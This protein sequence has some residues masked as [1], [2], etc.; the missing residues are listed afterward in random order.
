MVAGLLCTTETFKMGSSATH[1]A[2]ASVP[3]NEICTIES[4]T[5][6]PAAE[7]AET[8]PHV[9]T[10][11]EMVAELDFSASFPLE[12]ASRH[13]AV[14]L[15][16]SPD[17]AILSPWD[18]VPTG[19]RSTGALSVGWAMATEEKPRATRDTRSATKRYICARVNT[20]G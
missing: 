10:P 17:M 8:G 3:S 19:D 2:T 4:F 15:V 16:P 11:P 14:T 18:T 12:E 9:A 13:T 6:V 20:D 1:T 7:R 5:S